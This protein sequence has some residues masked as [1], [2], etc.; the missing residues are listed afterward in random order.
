MH[1]DYSRKVKMIVTTVVSC[2]IMG[3]LQLNYEVLY[4]LYKDSCPLIG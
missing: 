4:N 2:K 3:P 1:F